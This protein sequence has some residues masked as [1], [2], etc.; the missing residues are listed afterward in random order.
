MHGPIFDDNHDYVMLRSWLNLILIVTG[1]LIIVRSTPQTI[2][3][4]IS[5]DVRF[6][7]VP[8]HYKVLF[9]SRLV[10][11]VPTKNVSLGTYDLFH[12]LCRFIALEEG[13]T[14]FPQNVDNLYLFDTGR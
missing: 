5:L 14:K 1:I 2:T 7:A 13:S 8:L 12:F 4:T 6:Q 10:A 3:I 11:T 9:V